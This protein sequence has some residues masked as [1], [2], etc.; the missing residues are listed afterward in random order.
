MRFSIR[1]DPLTGEKYIAVPV[2]GKELLLNP[3]LNKGTAY[4]AREREELDLDGLLPPAIST[5]KQQLERAY[6]NFHSHPT[7]LGRYIFLTSLHDRNEVLFY[8]LLDKH[9]D[10]M[11][12]IVYT[13]LVGE[14]CQKFSHIY[15]K[16]RGI[17]IAYEQKDR[18]EQILINS[19]LTNPSVIVVTDGERILG[20]GDQGAGGMGIPVG[21][22]CL[23]TL[24]AGLSPYSALPIM[25]DVGT[26]NE[27]RLKDPLYL[28][29]RHRRVRGAK[30]QEFIDAFVTA[31][32]RV[33]PDAI[34]QWEDLLK[35]N[36]IRQLNL[37][38]DT[39]C[40]FNDDIQGTA[41]VAVAGI[42]SALRITGKSLTDQR[43]LIAGAGAS[44][45]G[46]SDLIVTAMMEDGLDRNE[47]VSRIYAV[48]S[49]GL[50]TSDRAGLEEFKAKYARSSTEVREW[51]VQDLSQISLVEAI[52]H[53]RPTIL[54]G[55]SGV[56]GIFT[57][58]VIHL[59]SAVNQHPIIFPLSNPTTRSE[60]TPKEA[61]L[62][63]EGRAIV[64]TRNA[65]AP[66]SYRGKQFRIGQANNAFIFP[67]VGLGLTISRSR[68]VTDY[69]FLEA[70]RALMAK[71]TDQD[72][73]E[74]A[75]YPQLSRIRECSH[76]VACAVIRKSVKEGFADEEILDHLEQRVDRAMWYPGYLPIRYDNEFQG[77]S[78]YARK[79]ANP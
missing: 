38:R 53:A 78:E 49:R 30:Y 58:K 67:G 46:I 6:E 25:L 39:L 75:V 4:T 62:W 23:Y 8:R 70:A 16:N 69:M 34:L 32:Q 15:R 43:V 45:Q 5:I 21:K 36:A 3:L 55:T 44:S 68:R 9:I 41:G 79:T 61:I 18:I 71:V 77:Q 40:T 74:N 52:K 19:G 48:D 26:D 59:M 22:L 31:V 54:L 51:D 47:A 7:L 11:L 1:I 56:P 64:A 73:D 12:P 60:C 50:V 37:F 66:V 33:F 63:S 2:K 76:A 17:Y 57:E 14:A 42:L 29:T 10:E 27:D 35:G 65:S 72:L 28:G 13:P 24:C 20:F